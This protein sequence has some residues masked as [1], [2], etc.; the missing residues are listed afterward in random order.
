MNFILFN[1]FST[2]ELFAAITLMLCIFKYRMTDYIPQ[3][4]LTSLVISLISHTMRFE[5]NSESWVP[6]VSLLTLFYFIWMLFRVSI[7]YAFIISFVGYLAYGVIQVVFLF[8][9]QFF[10]YFSLD[11]ALEPYSHITYVLQLIT[12]ILAL[13][14]AYLLRR[15]NYGFNWVPYSKKAKFDL[16]GGN[17][18]FFIV[19][20]I[21]VIAVG[22]LFHWYLAGYINLLANFILFFV[23]LAVLFYLAGRKE[24]KYYD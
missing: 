12:S 10:G 18:F 8:S 20:F 9:L 17:F 11:L 1:L 2:V 7:I 13:S 19:V 23:V 4:I 14:V 3:I 24:E 6:L 5:L 16:K 21:S 15:K 22:L